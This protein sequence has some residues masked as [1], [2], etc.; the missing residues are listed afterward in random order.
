MDLA[1]GVLNVPLAWCVAMAVLVALLLVGESM[2]GGPLRALVKV[3]AS[4]AYVEAAMWWGAFDTVYGRWIVTALV[5][6]WWGDVFL[7]S[8]NSRAFMAGLVSFLLGHVAY[9]FAF[10]LSGLHLT[11]TIAA[12]VALAMVFFVVARWL[13]PKVASNFRVPVAAYMLVISAMVALAFGTVGR[14]ASPIIALAAMSFYL[15]DLAV[16]RDRFIGENLG[17]RLWGLPAYYG[18][19]ILLALSVT[20]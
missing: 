17:N 5:C 20:G 15:S 9:C 1:I 13:L 19:Q 12:A 6:C 3:M 10:A 14:G 7:L 8:R 4:S 11:W 2:G 18:A 16:A